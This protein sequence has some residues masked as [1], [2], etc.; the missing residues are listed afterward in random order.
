MK[1]LRRPRG[2]LR[3]RVGGDQ[4]KDPHVLTSSVAGVEA[5]SWVN[6]TERA[7]EVGESSTE[8]TRTDERYR[9]PAELR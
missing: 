1:L 5:T 9:E 7:H 3:R 2:E 8:N 6:S 4:V